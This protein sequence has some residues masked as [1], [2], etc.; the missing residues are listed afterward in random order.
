MVFLHDFVSSREEDKWQ[1]LL[2]V[3]DDQLRLEAPDKREMTTT[4]LSGGQKR[5]RSHGYITDKETKVRS[6]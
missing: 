5:G 4:S 3:P 6:T 2:C 1:C